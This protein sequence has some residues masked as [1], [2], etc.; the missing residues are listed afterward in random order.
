M[1]HTGFPSD[2]TLAAFIDGRLDPE[3]RR[4]VVEH[5]SSCNE[6][7]SVFLAAG[8]LKAGDADFAHEPVA[9]RFTFHSRRVAGV[10]AALAAAAAITA[11][12]VGPIRE[13]YEA[14][15]NPLKRLAAA[16]P[17]ERRLAARL[18]GFP[19]RPFA[20]PTRGA[21][22]R[23][24]GSDSALW[25]VYA[26]A[27]PIGEDAV[28]HPTVEN[29]HAFGV[30][31]VLVGKPQQAVTSLEQALRKDAQAADVTSAIQRSTNAPLLNDLAAAY[32][33]LAKT[34]ERNAVSYLAAIDAAER[35]FELQPK[36]P[37][38]A[39]NR[40]LAIANLH[41]QRRTLAAWDAYLALDSTSPWAAEARERRSKA[42][43]KSEQDEWRELQPA[44]RAAAARGD[45][46]LLVARIGDHFQSTRAAIGE[47]LR[48][49]DLQLARALGAALAEATGDSFGTEPETALAMLGRLDE[50]K[51]RFQSGDY[52]AVIAGSDSLAADA[53]ARGHWSIAGKAERFSALSSGILGQRYRAISRYRDALASYEKAREPESAAA[54]HALLAEAEFLVGRDEQ[55]WSD[56]LAAFRGMAGSV[57]TPWYR[58]MLAL[59]AAEALKSGYRGAASQMISGAIT[60][61]VTSD[62]VSLHDALVS[63]ADVNRQLNRY[64]D[65][66]RDITRARNLEGQIDS[67]EQRA[68]ASAFS[69]LAEAAITEVRAPR[70]TA[71]R[72][73]E[74]IEYA[75]ARGDRYALPD[76]HYA[77]ANALG[78]AAAGDAAV[79]TEL[80]LGVAEMERQFAGAERSDEIERTADHL[81]R[82]TIAT[83]I[84][85]Q[86]VDEALEYCDR[87][88]EFALR[89][90]TPALVRAKQQARP[91][92]GVVYLSYLFADGALNIFVSR[93]GMNFLRHTNARESDIEALV[94]ERS[95]G[96]LSQALIV[97]VESH[98]GAADVIAVVPDRVLHRVPFAALQTSDGRALVERA[99]VVRTPFARGTLA[100]AGERV[101]AGGTLVV[102]N[103]AFDRNAFSQ[104]LDLPQ[105]EE[106]ARDVAAIRGGSEPLLRDRATKRAFL[107]AAPS[108]RL[109]HVGSH[110]L[111]NDRQPLDSALLLA[112]AAQPFDDGVL[113]AR[114]IL[115]L[116]LGKTQLV[117]LSACEG[118][119]ANTTF[120][121]SSL[122][123]AFISAG[124][125]NVV[126]SL[127]DVKDAQAAEFVRRFHQRIAAGMNV[128]A[129]FR[130]TQREV[131]H[132]SRSSGDLTWA[133][134]ELTTRSIA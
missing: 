109:I 106:E 18:T 14:K 87:Y 126:A 80:R 100:S 43:A 73:S 81:Y 120:A 13:R 128:L 39:W 101:D 57:D 69:T 97:P 61:R 92:S 117:V 91:M 71:E 116:P 108:A 111:A 15:N 11:V 82:S 17:K 38:I 72:L 103:P 9:H 2:E 66:L 32:M 130:D 48:H 59:T 105:A 124:A 51:L 133:G 23:E 40:A 34:S 20:E 50:L 75:Q 129:A 74:A 8:E 1:E 96:P 25:K 95:I 55:A 35:A 114:D 12:F 3:T 84:R 31:L 119:R 64:D 53:R 125:H 113:Y 94:N 10:A 33:E 67:P 26:V 118:G 93:D 107:A 63:R 123:D 68:R 65:A 76:L 49:N 127:W 19:Y 16:A 36:S 46:R 122:A 134:F 60:P 28:A 30:S 62:I 78:R 7:Y 56:Q 21:E 121:G 99:A 4:K 85:L 86:A 5:M 6:C 83:L 110:G 37:E 29:L 131:L 70:Q 132:A 52:T 115:K 102:G 44:I 54:I 27:G 22:S 79:L 98:L 58:N 77:K 112:T 104:L 47:A 24:A 42:M 89:A 90:S 41:N 45:T 88:R